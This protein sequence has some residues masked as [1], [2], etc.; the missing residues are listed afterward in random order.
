MP[1]NYIGQSLHIKIKN[2]FLLLILKRFLFN[3][4]LFIY[5]SLAALG[6]GCCVQALT[7]EPPGKPLKHFDME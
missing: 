1:V 6:L 4:Y 7:T 3:I 5:L 2:I